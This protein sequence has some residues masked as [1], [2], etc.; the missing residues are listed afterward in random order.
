MS[1]RHNRGDYRGD[2]GPEGNRRFEENREEHHG[3]SRQD[4]NRQGREGG[5]RGREGG[6]FG[7]EYGSWRQGAGVPGGGLG[8]GRDEDPGEGPEMYGRDMSYGHGDMNSDQPGRRRSDDTDWAPNRP[9]RGRGMWSGDW[10]DER[11]GSIGSAQSHTGEDY[12]GRGPKDYRRSDDRI[13][14]EVCDRLTD[15]PRVDA[16]EVT[17]RVEEGEVILAGSVPGRDQKRRAEECVERITGVREVINQ[18]RV[19]RSD[20]S[21]PQSTSQQSPG[22]GQRASSSVQQPGGAA[23]RSRKR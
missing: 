22:R 8:F 2:F 18:L 21:S 13:R 1:E 7:S 3:R 19:S 10:A 5:Q 9:A 6:G 4:S 12:R 14:E 15:D 16:S 20:M 17:I 23:A 11:S